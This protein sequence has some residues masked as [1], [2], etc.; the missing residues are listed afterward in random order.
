MAA[1]RRRPPAPQSEEDVVPGPRR[2]RAAPLPRSETV[3]EESNLEPIVQRV[4]GSR[5]SRIQGV[6]ISAADSSTDPRASR[7]VEET[8]RSRLT[9]EGPSGERRSTRPV[10]RPA[11]LQDYSEEERR[12]RRGKKRKSRSSYREDDEEE[13]EEQVNVRRRDVIMSPKTKRKKSSSA[14]NY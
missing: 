9:D 1:P 10:V 12:S 13:E 14:V 3:S 4:R 11:R 8:S 2:R 6:T 7:V 5:S